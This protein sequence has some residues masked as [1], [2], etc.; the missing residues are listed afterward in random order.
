MGLLAPKNKAARVAVTAAAGSVCRG[1]MVAGKARI[2]LAKKTIS[3]KS[4][5]VVLRQLKVGELKSAKEWTLT[6]TC[7]LKGKQAK[8]TKKIETFEAL[9]WTR[10]E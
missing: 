2:A 4:G 9:P 6:I 1:S 3:A 7:T 5:A 8:V 10:P